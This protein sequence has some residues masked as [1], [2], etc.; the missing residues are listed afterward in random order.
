MVLTAKDD[1]SGITTTEYG[2]DGGPLKAYTGPIAVASPGDHTLAY[3]SID[4]DGAVETTKQLSF[5]VVA[6]AP[7]GSVCVK[8]RLKV[9]LVNP[10][11]HKHGVAILR[12]GQAY[13]YAGRLTC[14]GKPAPKGTAVWI[15]TVAKGQSSSRPGVTVN[16]REDRHPAALRRQADRRLLLRRRRR[17]REGQDANRHHPRR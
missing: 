10:L 13:R 15:S 6:P 1:S 9:R 11:R 3:R 4:G 8:P 17:L 2:L 12:Q 7:K 16:G 5:T 14:G